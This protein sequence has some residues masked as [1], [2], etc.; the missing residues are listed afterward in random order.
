MFSCLLVPSLLF[1]LISLFY[2]PSCCCLL[3]CSFTFGVGNEVLTWAELT[4]RLGTDPPVAHP[5][6]RISNDALCAELVAVQRFG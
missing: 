6:D 1:V 2:V 5:V 4:M 3:S